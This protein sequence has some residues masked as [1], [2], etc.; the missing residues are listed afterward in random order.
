MATVRGVR[1]TAERYRKVT[2]DFTARAHAVPDDGWD[3][4]APCEG[5]VARGIVRHMVDTAG[6]FGGGAGVE[7][8]KGPSVDDDPVAA[9]EG[10]REAT[11]AALEDPEVAEREFESPMGQTT[12]DSMIARFGVADVLIH[13]WD[14]SRA[15]GLH[16]TLDPDEVQRVYELMLPNDEMLRQGTA[17]GPKVDVPDDADQQMKLIAFTGRRP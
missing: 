16:E 4:P 12:L 15:V 9:W 13:T 6:F 5:W 11:L 2:A 1:E 8:P 17:F 3:R 10:V 7:M 14:L